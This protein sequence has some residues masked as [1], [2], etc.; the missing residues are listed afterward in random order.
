MKAISFIDAARTMGLMKVISFYDEPTR[1]KIINSLSFRQLLNFRTLDGGRG[2]G[3]V[4]LMLAKAQTFA[5]WHEVFN[6]SARNKKNR[7]AAEKGMLDT[8]VTTLQWSAVYDLIPKHKKMAM[9]N[10]VKLAD[11]LADWFAVF[12][13]SRGDDK[14]RKRVVV[15]ATKLTTTREDWAML[16]DMVCGTKYDSA[17]LAEPGMPC[18]VLFQ[19]WVNVY[20]KT[21]RSRIG[22]R[23]RQITRVLVKKATAAQLDIM[24]KLMIEKKVENPPAALSNVIAEKAISEGDYRMAYDNFCVPSSRNRVIQTALI[25]DPPFEKLASLLA[26]LIP[27]TGRTD[28]RICNRLLAKASS[29]KQFALVYKV[30]RDKGTTRKALE[31]MLEKASSFSELIHVFQECDKAM[32]DSAVERLVKASIAEDQLSWLFSVAS[33]DCKPEIMKKFV[34]SRC[35]MNQA[36][37]IASHAGDVPSMAAEIVAWAI[38]KMSSFKHLAELR[39]ELPKRLRPAVE[40]KMFRMIR[41]EAS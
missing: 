2:R 28:E 15:I 30:S 1:K 4:D 40:A 38:G 3:V 31:G 32:K 5:E 16:W 17:V 27:T 29:F 10:M 8:A 26:V 21:Y 7:L 25:K 22:G 39:D 37:I 9:Q 20:G 24:F 33:N 11:S 35:S 6:A 13:H 14:L 18:D 12:R 36:I 23:E 41:S 19:Y 34:K